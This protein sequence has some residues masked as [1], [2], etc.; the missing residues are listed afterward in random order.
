MKISTD[1]SNTTGSCHGTHRKCQ[2]LGR[3]RQEE[4]DMEGK[5]EKK[6]IPRFSPSVPEIRKMEKDQKWQ[7]I[8]S[9]FC[10]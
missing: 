4:L 7:R 6:L 3:Q 10:P 8:R 9:S 5:G 1:K 2:L